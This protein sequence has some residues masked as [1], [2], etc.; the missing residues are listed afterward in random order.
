MILTPEELVDLTKR[1]RSNAQAKVL[2]HLGIEFKP[3]PDGSLVVARASVD[4]ALGLSPS[5]AKIKDFELD[6][7]AVS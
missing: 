5:S 4:A 3:R 2:R 1:Q 7:S 6:L